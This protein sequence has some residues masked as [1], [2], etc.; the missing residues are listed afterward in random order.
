MKPDNFTQ[1][2]W[3]RLKLDKFFGGITDMDAAQVGGY[4]LLLLYQWRN[5]SIPVSMSELRKISKLKPAQ[6]QSII[7]KFKIGEDGKYYNQPCRDEYLEQLPKY[8][9]KVAQI[10]EVNARKAQKSSTQK[11]THTVTKSVTPTATAPSTVAPTEERIENIDT[12]NV[13]EEAAADELQALQEANEAHVTFGKKLLS[14]YAIKDREDI[15]LQV[16]EKITPDIIARFNAHLYTDRKF[17]V[18][19][20]P[21][22]GHLKAWMPKRPKQIIPQNTPAATTAAAKTTWLP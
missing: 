4:L 13:V 6:I 9:K 11:P 18:H 14:V 8:L 15:E 7:S 5:W 16:G 17:H 3:M 12:T 10:E 22:M 21:Y 20:T 2:P 1:L 19:F